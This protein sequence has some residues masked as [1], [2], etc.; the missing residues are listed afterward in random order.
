MRDF[1]ILKN[2]IESIFSISNYTSK[3][4]L[5]IIISKTPK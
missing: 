4:F 2:D 3:E 1:L 5:V